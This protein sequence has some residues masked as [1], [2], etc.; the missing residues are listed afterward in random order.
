MPR[1]VGDPVAAQD[2]DRD[3]QQMDVM[4]SR[5]PVA[6]LSMLIGASARTR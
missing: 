1:R 2:P 5:S 3:P 4:P 6:A